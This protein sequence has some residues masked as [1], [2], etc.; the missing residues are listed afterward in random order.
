M[1]RHQTDPGAGLPIADDVLRL[2]PVLVLLWCAGVYLRLTMLVA[3]PL[4]PHIAAD[5]GLDEAGIGALTTLPVLAL[6]LGSV[7]AALLIARL[8]ARQA[9]ALALIV[10]AAGSSARGLAGEPLALF[11]ATALM[12]LGIAVMQPALPTLLTHWCPQRIALGTAVYMNGMLIG[13][14]A[15]AGLTLPVVMPLVDDDWRLALALWS[16]PA[17][18]VAALLLLRGQ[19]GDDALAGDYWMPRWRDPLIWRLGILLGGTACLF[20]GTN[21]Y[22]GSVLS[23]RG[24]GD[25]LAA[26]LVMLNGSQVVASLFM[27]PM[28]RLW[29][30][31]PGP[32][33]LSSITGALALAGFMLLPGWAGLAGVALVGFCAGVLLIL[34]VALPPLY[35]SN[36]GTA[37]I[38][39]GMFT[40]GYGIS[41]AVP[42]VGGA[43]SE[44]LGTPAAVLWPILGY[45]GFSLPL[46]LG[47]P[48][49]ATH[50]PDP[51]GS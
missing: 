46:A 32:L 50:A 23:A 28:A 51:I 39:A 30:G 1:E 29:V 45:V 49:P 18:L 3:P 2:L 8:G 34:L 22:L 47:L 12:G 15:G 41:F 27:L 42:L 6:A 35:A 10:V 26:G 25:R 4:A 38:S 20:F 9:L 33:L 43:L 7:V 13:E 19:G 37:A 44:A 11:A 36:S 21:A 31:R 14:I 24:E 16:A 5:L 48:K 40:V 17:L